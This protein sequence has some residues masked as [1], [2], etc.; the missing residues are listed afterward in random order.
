VRYIRADLFHVARGE[1]I[2]RVN[3]YDLEVYAS[4]E[5]KVRYEVFRQIEATQGLKSFSIIWGES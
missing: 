2:G 5:E 1:W 3:D 4:S